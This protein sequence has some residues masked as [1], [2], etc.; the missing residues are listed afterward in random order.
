M[1]YPLA[2]LQEGFFF[3]AKFDSSQKTAPDVYVTQLT[4][5]F[6]GELCVVALRHACDSLVRRHDGLRAGFRLG[7]S[8]E[9]VQFIAESAEVP[10]RYADARQS[11]SAALLLEERLCGFDLARPPLIR[12]LL[13]QLCDT[14][15]RL[16]VTNH[17]IILD[18]WSTS[19]L[20]NELLALY[21]RPF[22]ELAP[23]PAYR[24]FLNWLAKEDF[25]EARH[26]WANAL[27][28]LDGPTLVAP[29]ASCETTATPGTV[30]RVV[31]GGVTRALQEQARRHGATL[32]SLLHVAWALVL[33]RLTGQDDVVFGTTVSGRDAPVDGIE[34]IVGLLINTLPVRVTVRPGESLGDLLRRVQEQQIDL[35]DSHHVGLGEI[36]RI[37]VSA[38]LFDTTTAFENYPV[39]DSD[40]ELGGVRL[41]GSGG[42]DATH[43][44]LSLLCT[45]GDELRFRVDYRE[46]VFDRPFAERIVAWL[47][48]LL[49]VFATAPD[50]PATDVD[51]LGDDERDRILHTWSGTTT[52]YAD[53]RNVREFFE[54]QAGTR[55]DATA[56][57]QG[58]ERLSFRELNSRANRL[59]R[60]LLEQGLGPEDRVAVLLDRSVAS[61]VAILAILKSGA[62]HVPLDGDSPPARITQ[63]VEAAQPRAL[64]TTRTVH[65][66]L[67]TVTPTAAVVWVDA[68]TGTPTGETRTDDPTQRNR[69]V[70]LLPAHPAY[71]L[72]TSGSTGA[73][74]GVVV[75]HR[76]LTNL[77][78]SYREGLFAD[79]LRATGE[80]AA[81]V[82]VTAPLTF[83][84]SWMG[85]LALFAG[86][87]LHLLDETTRRDPAALVA[88]IG[89][90]RIDF[91]DTTPTYA[92]EMLE[93]GL[94]ATPELTPATFTLGG[95]PIPDGLWRRILAEPAVT[96]HNFYGPTECTVETLTTH[97]TATPSPTIGR[98]ID[99]VRAYVLDES[100]RLVPLGVTGELYIGGNGLARGYTSAVQTAERFVACPF[101][102]GDRMY[103]SGDLVRWRDDGSLEFCG[104]GDDQV[105]LRGFRIELGEIET[106]LTTHPALAQALVVVRED[107]PGRKLLVAYVVPHARQDVTPAE[108]RRFVTAA[109]P[110]HLVPAAYVHLESLPTTDNG[111]RDRSALP[112]PDRSA[113]AARSSRLPR[114]PLERT[115]CG[116]FAEVLGTDGIG[117]DDAFFEL[118][119][120]SLLATRLVG[121]IHAD[122]GVDL[123]IR[124]IFETPTVAGLVALTASAVGLAPGALKPVLT[125]REAGG[126]APVFC[127]HPVT[128]LGWCYAGLAA[129]LDDRPVYALQVHPEQRGADRPADFAALIDGYVARIREIQP[130]GPY[131][132][133][134][135]SLGGNI[136]HAMACRLQ[137]HGEQ[138]ALLAL[139]DS[140]PAPADETTAPTA[141]ELA[142]LLR[143]EAGTGVRLDPLDMDEISYTA[144]A[145]AALVEVAEPGVFAGDLLHVTATEGRPVGART[146]QHWQR[147]TSGTIDAR[148]IDCDHL[149]M[150]RERPLAEISTVLSQALRSDRR[151]PHRCC[152]T[153]FQSMS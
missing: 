69:T 98:P 92:L 1:R 103:R 130:H 93:Y 117:I 146:A 34:S 7:E 81:R 131:H 144:A 110:A 96:G 15:W 13:V 43:Y 102:K 48:R 87:E 41:A 52:E 65:E 77:F 89:H 84:A 73:Q 83:D 134:G 152:K 10:W 122:L 150:L 26:A 148:V 57:V 139:L 24:D 111:K 38:R 51:V 44:P 64:I 11:D 46:D 27:S 112:V 143:Q 45:P 14:R 68:R 61:I 36:Q 132:L 67:G 151:A 135:W 140:Y 125:L 94:L 74:K 145:V 25:T 8:G 142:A 118:G 105:K 58:E 120:D 72:H 95:E 32:N 100:L 70:P 5:D 40:T 107:E 22:E 101:G 2:P 78:H 115:L 121:R 76:S 18:G 42:F 119:G 55:S 104:R 79:H 23:A 137:E 17:H 153:P 75:E 97:L 114:T 39:D 116:L 4:L 149:G 6:E 3:H 29:A 71:V 123:P 33:R 21:Q 31:P 86:H 49:D 90:H 28:G 16:A 59:A 62:A 85:L 60:T 30:A 113:V 19:L 47:D 91:L 147:F 35:L 124:A 37:S 126:G 54:E 53:Q 138:T 82:V 106:V 108:L 56:L 9:P 12:F 133:V 128:G 129:A 66:R 63:V 136:A 50:T 88:Y 99:N 141:K 109:L 80:A 20:V 127:V